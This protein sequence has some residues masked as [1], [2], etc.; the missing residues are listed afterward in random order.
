MSSPVDNPDACAVHLNRV[1]AVGRDYLF[2]CFTDPSLLLRWWGPEG[3]SCVNVHSD[4]V[5][6]GTY[7]FE[8]VGD[9]SG[10]RNVVSGEYLVVE[11]PQRLVFS[12]AWD[13]TAAEVTQVELTFN[14]ISP[15]TTELVLVHSRFPNSDRAAAHN[16][17]WDSSFD[18]LEELLGSKA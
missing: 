15:T 2:Q 11:P 12:W 18:C 16:Q 4:A 17:G 6:G 5:A 1:F 14:A 13:A 8:I 3:A 7:R 9:D 10:E